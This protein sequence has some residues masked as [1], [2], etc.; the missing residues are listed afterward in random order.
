[1]AYPVLVAIWLQAQHPVDLAEL[2][3]AIWR[4]D[5]GLV[6]NLAPFELKPGMINFSCESEADDVKAA[7]AKARDVA[8]R[9]VRSLDYPECRISSVTVQ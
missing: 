5:E 2:T 6:F 7:A 8:F 1:V 4:V 9:A 3:E